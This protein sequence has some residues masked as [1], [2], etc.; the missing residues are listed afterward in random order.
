MYRN[1]PIPEDSLTVWSSQISLFSWQKAPPVFNKK[2]FPQIWFFPSKPQT[3]QE[4]ISSLGLKPWGEGSSFSAAE[5]N[6]SYCFW[7]PLKE[8]F[9]KKIKYVVFE[10]CQLSVRKVIRFWGAKTRTAT[11]I[12]RTLSWKWHDMN[13]CMHA[14]LSPCLTMTFK[15]CI[16]KPPWCLLINRAWGFQGENLRCFDW[17]WLIDLPKMA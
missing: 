6:L 3:G 1:S 9:R 11:K 14:I 4:G 2:T 12:N 10:S 15:S 16:G 13:H 7:D 8:I 17:E 5:K